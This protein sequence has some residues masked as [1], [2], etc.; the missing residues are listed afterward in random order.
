MNK[1]NALFL[2]LS[3]FIFGDF[4]AQ[5]PSFLIT[6]SC[7]PT[8]EFGFAPAGLEV[9][10]HGGQFKITEKS[11]SGKTQSFLLLGPILG[12]VNQ[13]TF[14]G[15]EVALT[16]P[17]PKAVQGLPSSSER[18][19]NTSQKE[20]AGVLCSPCGVNNW[21][22]PSL[23][24]P[25]NGW[26]GSSMPLETT[27]AYGNISYRIN[28]TSIERLSDNDFRRS[29][30]HHNA[31]AIDNDRTVV[32]SREFVELFQLSPPSDVIRY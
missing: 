31:F 27:I 6:Y 32:D 12:S 28:V 10:S 5:T 3:I 21:C 25:P 1:L 20:L 22:A 9:I 29:G 13:F 17:L 14:F 11:E 2:V 4:S 24:P 8:E 19:A 23:G 16:G 18:G 15:T 30:N 7:S 26:P